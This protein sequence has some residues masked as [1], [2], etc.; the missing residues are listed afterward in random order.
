MTNRPKKIGTAFESQCV[1]WLGARLGDDRIE[2][3]ALHGSRDMGDIHGLLAH[4]AQGI[5]ECKAHKRVT[6]SLVASWREQTEAERCNADADFALLLVK[7][8]GVGDATFGRTE[9]QLTVASL[10]AVCGAG[11]LP[12]ALRARVG[13]EW[14]SLDL[15][16]ACRLM[17][18]GGADG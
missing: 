13:E 9:C 12:D 18:W 1:R 6:P 2:R 7:T 16:A 8:A 4:G 14:V 10:M 3:R 17:T 15:E 5:A 11:G